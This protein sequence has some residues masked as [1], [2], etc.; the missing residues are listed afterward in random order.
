MIILGGTGVCEHFLINRRRA[1]QKNF[2]N[3]YY[4]VLEHNKCNNLFKHKISDYVNDVQRKKGG[5]VMLY[6]GV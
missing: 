3:H 4:S 2:G 6:I 5:S 1:Q